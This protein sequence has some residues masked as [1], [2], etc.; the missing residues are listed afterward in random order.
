MR[1]TRSLSGTWQFQLDPDGS[2]TVETLSPDREIP[3]PLPWQVAFPD[4]APYSGYAWYHRSFDLDAESL[5]GELLLHFGAVDYWCEIFV[6]GQRVGGHEGGYTP[7]TLPIRN[8]V[9][10]GANDI[11]VRVYD[12]AQTQISL[13]RW[14]DYTAVPHG[15]PPFDARNIPHG[16]QEWYINVGGIWQDITLTAVPK[17]F[18]EQ[19]HVI[20]HIASDEAPAPDAAPVS[21]AAHFTLTLGGDSTHFTNATARI[22]LAGQDAGVELTTQGRVSEARL[23]IPNPRLW[24]LADPHLYRATV[25]LHTPHGDDELDVR[26]GLREISTRDGQLLLNGEP[27]FLLSALDQDFYPDTIYTVPSDE[28]LRDQ[29]C[30]AQQ[31]G[32][33]CLRCHIK[34]PDPRYLELADEMGLL[35]WAEIPSWR[36]FYPK[37]TLHPDQVRLDDEIKARVVQTLQEMIARDTNHPSIIIWTIVNEDWGTSLPL[38]AADRAWVA[39]M[40][41]LCKSLDPT[42]LVVD[43]SACPH[44][45]GPNIHV[46]SDLDDFHVYANI[47]DNAVGFEQSIEEFN[48][49]PLWTWSNQGDAQRR[50]DEPLILSEFGNWGLPSLR[51]LREHYG[52]EPSWFDLGPWWSGW[53][54]EPGFPRG[55]EERFHTLGLDTIWRDYEA[56]AAATQWHEFAALKFEIETMRRQPSLAGYVIT[57][58]ADTYWESNGLLDFARN[59]KVFHQAFAAVNAPDMLVPEPQHYGSWDDD[60]LPVRVHGSHFGETDWS[61]AR[62]RCVIEGGGVGGEREIEPQGRGT[63]RL[64]DER[65]WKLPRVD[66]AQTLQFQFSLENQSG[67]PLAHNTLDILVL[68]A[69]ARRANYTRPVAVITAER[70]FALG[71]SGQAGL[72]SQDTDSIQAPPHQGSVPQP[73]P[74]LGVARYDLATSLR[75]IGYQTFSHLDADSEVAV[76]NLPTANLL[77]WVR[78]GGKLLFL[79]SGP[80]PFFWTQGRGGAYSGNWMTSFTWLRTEIHKRLQVTNPLG[81]PFR[82]VMPTRTILGLPVEDPAVQPDFLAGTIS[83]WLRHPAIHTVQFRYGQGRVIMTTFAFEDSLQNRP[84]AVA[85]FHDLMDHLVSDACDPILKANY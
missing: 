17:T 82:Y 81:L 14:S 83:G 44:G 46:K 3:V 49:R 20:P 24:S 76:T 54:G 36:T 30:K 12:V 29:F 7:F 59:P 41:D 42:R 65:L 48:L 52:G 22:T 37:G 78:D 61:G 53:E 58:F 21:G 26:F 64:L 45:W 35:V 51:L 63:V 16:K 34:P 9:H 23:T 10:A 25:R 50:G 11:A 67:Q 84:A 38:S 85:L 1:L 15:G 68:P 62:V 19:V 4:L 31:L 72:T 79:S 8:Y 57:E 66:A 70:V 75:R 32:L 43:N 33:N 80:S 74:S 5:S 47:P 27:I 60:P 71:A 55:V 2:L 73:A 6:N 69:H 39:E 77:R 56:F 18:I 40:Y 28:F 13:P